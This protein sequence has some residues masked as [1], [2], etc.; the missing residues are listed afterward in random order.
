MFCCRIKNNKKDDFKKQAKTAV[1][2][3]FNKEEIYLK[4]IFQE[5]G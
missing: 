1:I 2:S 4:C 5:Q 3:R